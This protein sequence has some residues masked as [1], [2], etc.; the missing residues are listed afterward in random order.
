[1]KLW[2]LEEWGAKRT[3][4]Q[5]NILYGATVWE[6]RDTPT[7]RPH[8]TIETDWLEGFR[9][10]TKERILGDG[11]GSQNNRKSR[12]AGTEASPLHEHDELYFVL[13][14]KHTQVPQN[15]GFIR[16]LQNH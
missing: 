8:I 7:D 1:M 10:M 13:E 11:G 3:N 9:E 15:A 6:N 14:E 12:N 5:L 16:R 2:K 4:S